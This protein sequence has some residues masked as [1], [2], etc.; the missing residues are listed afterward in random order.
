MAGKT[1]LFLLIFA[2]L[3]LQAEVYRCD[4]ADGLVYSQIPCDENAEI[5][6]IYDPVAKAEDDGSEPDS[7]QG[8]A[9]EIVE[10]PPTPM[11]N[12]IATLNGQRQQQIGEIDATIA[13]LKGL[14]NAEGEQ[15]L[16]EEDRK[17]VESQ[18]ATLQSDR[19]SIAEQYASMI[20]EAEQR[21][22]SVDAIN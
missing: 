2:P 22:G 3:S 4:G 17:A 6:V 9:E 8:E 13:H 15:A 7:G 1:L 21:T 5:V 12:F 19:N 10:K 20:S 11:E 18:L 16:E 14:L